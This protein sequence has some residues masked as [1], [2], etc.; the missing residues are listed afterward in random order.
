MLNRR[1]FLKKLF[2]PFLTAAL[3]LSACAGTAGGPESGQTEAASVPET[4]AAAETEDAEPAAAAEE[5]V[6]RLAITEPIKTM[7]IDRTTTDYMLPLNIYERLFDI[8]MKEDGTT[9]LVGGLVKNYS[10]GRDGR[11]YSFTLWDNAFFSDGTPVTASDV[12]F[13]FT[14]MLSL[15]DS[16]QTDFAD[17]I[18]GAEAVLAHETDKL[19][20]IQVIDDTH[21]KITLTEPF[22]GYLY[23]LAT[24]SCSILSKKCVN[25]NGFR[26]GAVAEATIG[27]GPY[28]VT[29]FSS[30]KICLE[31]NPYYRG[32]APSVK[33]VEIRVMEPAILEEKFRA[34]DLDVLDVS[35]ISSDTLESIYRSEEWK[36]RLVS[37]ACANIRY[38]M[39][40]VEAEPLNDLRVRKAVQMAINRQKILDELFNGEGML[41]DGIY[42]KNLNGYAEE[43]Q[44]WLTYDPEGAKALLEEAGLKNGAKIELAADSTSSVTELSMID[45]IYKDLMAAGFNASIV[46]YDSESRTYLRKAGKLMAYTGVWSADYNDPDNFIYTFFG[47]RDKTRF[48]SGNFSGEE[49]MKRIR[50][51][52]KIQDEG[53]RL[54]EY[55]ALERMLI[56]KEALWVPLLSSNQLFVLGNRVESLT[57][58]WAGWEDLVFK[59]IVLK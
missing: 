48:C 28:K 9:E 55:A 41:I 38:L 45:M 16:Q 11:T 58:Y 49:V 39:L 34:G 30:E 32:T 51:A 24:P 2:L 23:Q 18:L 27:S 31:L 1:S 46:N 56:K 19:E 8:R 52:R 26:F 54:R 15:S 3:L 37:A 20:G 43:N 36:D 6:L 13:S 33:K 5:G 17:A 21:F 50:A 47:S 14:R 40:N 4:Q 29:E 57:P 44:G 12:E 35:Y 10:L 22:A 7:D 42:P 25:E 59:D 53:K